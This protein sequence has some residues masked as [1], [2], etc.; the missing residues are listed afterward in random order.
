M[1]DRIRILIIEDE[2]QIREFLIISLESYNYEIFET[3]SGYDALKIIKR[4][5]PEII[6]LDLGLPDIDGL[7]LIKEIRK[8]H[9]TPI[10]VLSARSA[11]Q[12]IILAL[13]HGADDYIVKPFHIGE[14]L[15]RLKVALRHSNQNSNL[16]T[17]KSGNLTIDFL[18]KTVRV[19][20]E[21]I[22]LT[23][24]EYTILLLL[25]NNAGKVLTHDYI[26]EKIWGESYIGELGNLRVQI[27]H[28]R[29]KIEED[30]SMPRL[31]SN[32]SG[33]GYRFNQID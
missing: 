4:E 21:T 27:A 3:E 29:K 5:Y 9:L 17:F 19:N 14:L 22:K 26:L 32:E 15:A 23:I 24:Q 28:I 25:V 31:I 33:V 16:R 6:I 13:N 12:D 20:G 1:E 30:P 7:E 18:T 2:P 8:K 11:E 10:I